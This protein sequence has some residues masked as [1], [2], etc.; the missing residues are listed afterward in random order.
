MAFD[1]FGWWTRESREHASA[2]AATALPWLDEWV[3][4]TT[5][6]VDPRNW[7]DLATVSGSSPDRALFDI[8]EGIARRFAGR[9][10]ELKRHGAT[11]R[12]VLDSL[13][14]ERTRPAEPTPTRFGYE[15]D[16]EASLEAHDVAWAG[17]SLEKVSAVIRQLALV[18][19]RSARVRAGVIDVTA[20]STQ[21][22]LVSALGP[23]VAG[24]WSLKVAGDGLVAARL[25]DRQL[26]L[27]VEPSLVRG[28]IHVELRAVAWRGL[29]L[30]VPGW[31]RLTR[32]RPVPPL[33]P[34]MEL[35]G[36]W[37]EDGAVTL[38]L[39]V[40]GLTETLDLARIRDAVL[41]GEPVLWVGP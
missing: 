35:L 13:R 21:E 12:F 8:L 20:R 6:W 5:W 9:R 38:R 17:W 27:V 36:A 33:P 25:D 10:V 26:E 24:R 22:A 39:R 34:G 15:N 4:A 19:G 30:S 41:C 29:R 14:L 3:K 40:S 2:S 28:V 37:A 32:T 11:L 23:S 7:A 31:L 1:P 18:P 16:V